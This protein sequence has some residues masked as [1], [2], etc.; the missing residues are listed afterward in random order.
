MGVGRMVVDDRV[1]E[2]ELGVGR[3]GSMEEGLGRDR[4]LLAL[5]PF[6]PDALPPLPPPLPS[7]PPSTTSTTTCQSPMPAPVLVLVLVVVVLCE[8]A[9]GESKGLSGRG[10]SGVVSRRC[11]RGS[12]E[13]VCQG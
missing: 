3:V 8:P 10:W 5:T 1:M 12:L 7:P 6:D 4:G 2:E 11:V 9:T 13:R